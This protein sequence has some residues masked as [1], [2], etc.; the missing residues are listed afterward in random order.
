MKGK[1]SFWVYNKESALKYLSIIIF[2]T[3]S[4]YQKKTTYTTW[5]NVYSWVYTA[6]YLCIWPLALSKVG[7]SF[8]CW[9]FNPPSS[10]FFLRI[11][12]TCFSTKRYQ[13]LKEGYQSYSLL[14]SSLIIYCL[15]NSVPGSKKPCIFH[16]HCSSIQ[17]LTMNPPKNP[18]N[19]DIIQYPSF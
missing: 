9:Y 12:W 10:H 13:M 15:T 6:A 7:T 2:Y 4:I 16:F 5:S 19:A 14:T 17:N 8:A 1:K 18:N 3:D 11:Y